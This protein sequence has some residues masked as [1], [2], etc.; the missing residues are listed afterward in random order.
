MKSVTAP[1]AGAEGGFFAFDTTLV[2]FFLAVDLGQTGFQL[3]LGSSLSGLSVITVAAAPYA[4]FGDEKPHFWTWLGSRL[5]LAGFGVLG[6]VLMSGSVG[7]LLPESA[8][9]VPITL[10]ILAAFLRFCLQFYGILRVRLAR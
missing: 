1:N 2:L 5:I 9:F 3:D 4:M 10:L 6:G 7:T 8:R